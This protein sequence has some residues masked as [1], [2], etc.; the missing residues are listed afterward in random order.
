MQPNPSTPDLGA[1]RALLAGMKEHNDA[2][3]NDLAGYRT[4]DGQDIR[5]EAQPDY[6]ECKDTYGWRLVEILPEWIAVLTDAL[7]TGNTP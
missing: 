6:E 2:W 5:E 1:L 4:D 7:A 3:E